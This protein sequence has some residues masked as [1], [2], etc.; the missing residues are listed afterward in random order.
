MPAMNYSRFNDSWFG[1]IGDMMDRLTGGSGRKGGMWVRRALAAVLAGVFW[2]LAT[3]PFRTEDDDGG[4]PFAALPFLVFSMAA[5]ISSAIM[6]APDLVEYAARP[7]TRWIDSIYLGSGEIEVPPLNY[8]PV[9]RAI[10]EKR[11]Q[12]AAFEFERISQ[13]YANEMRPYFDGIMA[14]RLANDGYTARELYRR[15]VTFFP[16]SENILLTRLEGPV[17][18]VRAMPIG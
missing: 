13:W 8:A 4:N 16:D 11:W 5:L 15:G 17:V 9:D 3:K 1:L 7:F 10:Q 6:I 12:Q 14:A 18:E 2:W